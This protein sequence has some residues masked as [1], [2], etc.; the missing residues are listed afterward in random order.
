MT[1]TSSNGLSKLVFWKKPPRTVRQLVRREFGVRIRKVEFYN[2]A[3]T[4][5]SM[6][7]GDA[8]G[9]RSNERLEFLGDSALGLVVASFLYESFPEEQEGG[10][11]QRKS[12]IVNRET[13]NRVGEKMDLK[14]FIRTKMR[15]SDVPATILGNALEALIGAIYLDHG[16]NKTSKAV[17]RML[18]KHGAD[19]KVHETVD[20]KSKLH[21]WSQREKSSLSFDVIREYQV[22]GKACYDVD[23]SIDG[24]KRGSGTGN[25]KKSAEQRAARSA[26]RSIFETSRPGRG[27][28]ED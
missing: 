11:T 7:D 16:Y 6:L 14:A 4:H 12:K 13:L 18:K 3:L 10:M 22:N 15:K 20:F 2:E 27:V 25:S 21:L 5:S 17:M 19:D 9:L 8:T 28:S 26:W 1:N 24:I 23:V